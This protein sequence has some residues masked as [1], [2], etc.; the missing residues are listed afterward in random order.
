MKGKALECRTAFLK[1]NVGTVIKMLHPFMPTWLH[2]FQTTATL[3]CLWPSGYEM[4]SFYLML[5]VFL[6][7]MLLISRPNW[8]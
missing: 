6:V 4:D 3:H 5:A 2:G 1:E 8:S 7:Q